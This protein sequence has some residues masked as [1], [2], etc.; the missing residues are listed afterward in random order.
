MWGWEKAPTL[1]S[2][3][4]AQHP[5]LPSRPEPQLGLCQGLVGLW[6]K[7][8]PCPTVGSPSLY[9]PFGRLQPG[10][11]LPVGCQASVT[12][13]HTFAQFEASGLCLPTSVQPA[14]RPGPRFPSTNEGA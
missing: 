11:P 5:K 13:T 3:L 14:C 8:G 12:Q 1:T 2:W 7:I 10:E 6:G 4:C 9:G